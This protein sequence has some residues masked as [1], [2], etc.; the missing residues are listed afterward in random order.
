MIIL[1]WKQYQALI[2]LHVH[3]YL[4]YNIEFEVNKVREA[5]L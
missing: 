4:Y 2:A 5:W 1:S 3:V